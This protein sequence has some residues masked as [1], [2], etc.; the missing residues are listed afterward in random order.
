MKHHWH[1]RRTQ[2]VTA[3][4]RQRWDK[5]YQSILA[6]SHLSQP[7]AQL[8]SIQGVQERRSAQVHEGQEVSHAR[9]DVC[10]R[11]DAEPSA[12]PDD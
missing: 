2:V 7:P 5:A 12:Q 8:E 3:D 4:G 10:A 6:W 9:S 1:S 11:L